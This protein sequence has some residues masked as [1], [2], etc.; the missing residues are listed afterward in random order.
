MF[1]LLLVSVASRIGLFPEHLEYLFYPKDNLVKV[2]APTRGGESL[3]KF[4]ETY[5]GIFTSGITCYNSSMTN[6]I[7]GPS[8][9]FIEKFLSVSALL[10]D[11]RAMITAVWEAGAQSQHAKNTPALV[12]NFASS[13]AALLRKVER[14]RKVIRN[15]VNKHWIA[16]P[17]GLKWTN[18]EEGFIVAGVSRNLGT[19]RS[20]RWVDI[21]DKIAAGETEFEATDF[22]VLRGAGYYNSGLSVKFP[23]IWFSMSD[24]DLSKMVREHVK[25]AAKAQEQA[26]RDALLKR[27]ASLEKEMA[28]LLAEIESQ[29]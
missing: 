1:G 24:G 12:E 17:A 28:K 27:K 6:T 5:S 11:P 25:E 10:T 9:E 2:P 26:N 19:E 13:N 21:A 20:Q 18:G 23:A 16:T 8:E 22:I 14:V 7:T 4:L 15:T 29:G 3:P